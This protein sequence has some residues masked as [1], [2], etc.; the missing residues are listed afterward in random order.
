MNINFISYTL[1]FLTLLS[2]FF[3]VFFLFYLFL[4]Y[5]NNK[6]KVIKYFAKNGIFFAFAVSIFSTLGSLYYS[7]I[8][9]FSPCKLCWYQRIFIYPQVFLLGLA[10]YK[11]QKV[12]IP[13]SLLLLIV[14]LL[15]SFYHN[16]IYFSKTS[17]VFCSTNDSCIKRYIYEFD[18]ISIPI[19]ALTAFILMILFLNLHLIF[20]KD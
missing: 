2:H 6:D 4:N 14:G 17:S 13:Y 12:I 16:L 20:C 5:K 9:G 1:G 19:M 15:F 11:K 8:L 10:L 3:L 7:D 18:Y